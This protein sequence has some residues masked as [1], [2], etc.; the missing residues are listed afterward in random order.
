[1][2]FAGGGIRGWGGVA[3]A[4]IAM[5]LMTYLVARSNQSRS[6]LWRTEL[7]TQAVL[8]QEHVARSG[9]SLA[10]HQCEERRDASLLRCSI[11][12]AKE[13]FDLNFCIPEEF[14][15]RMKRNSSIDATF[16]AQLVDGSRVELVLHYQARTQMAQASI[17]FSA[18]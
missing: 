2:S 4:L 7:T 3:F 15:A 8:L 16:K 10:G 1:V 13:L 14:R 12:C 5:A 18:N 6:D 17:D 9:W 11:R